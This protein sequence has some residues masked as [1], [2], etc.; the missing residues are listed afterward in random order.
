MNKAEF[1]QSIADEVG[2]WA[3]TCDEHGCITIHVS[4]VSRVQGLLEAYAQAHIDSAQN[5]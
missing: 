4:Y 1:L 2:K 3:D 5:D